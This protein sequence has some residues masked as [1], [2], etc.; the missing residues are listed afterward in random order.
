MRL[1]KNILGNYTKPRIFLCDTNKKKICQLYTT[2]TRGSFKFNSCSELSFET[3]RI[4]NDVLT[5][6][7]KVNP[8]YDR[9]ESPRLILLE[10]F[11]YFEIQCPELNSDGIKESKSVTAYSLEYTLSTKFLKNFYVNTGKVDSL[12]VLN[13][14]NPD[15]I[16][17]IV[18]CDKSNPKLSLLHL[19]LEE[20]YGW[21]VGYVSPSLQT[22]SRQF[23]V[24]RESVYD[25]LM[26]EICE[27]FNCYIV[28]DTFNNEINIYAES[29]TSK[30][31][32]DGSTNIF[33]ISPPFSQINTVSVDGYKT[34]RWSYNAS[35]GVL[36]LEDIPVYGARIEIIDGSLK[37]W[38]TDVFVSFDNLAKDVNVSYDADAI[39]TKL[40]VTYGDDLDIREA[41]LGLPYLTDLS[42]YYNVDWMGQD[43]YD[44]YTAYLQ[45]S[46]QY[47]T[48]YTN[49]SQAMLDIAGK[50]DFAENRLSLEYAKVSV[51][52]TA[53]GTYYV[54]VGEYPNHYYREVTLPADYNVNTTYYSDETTNLQDTSEGNVRKLYEALKKYFNNTN[55]WG[56]ELSALSDLFVFMH[57][58]PVSWL[59]EQLNAVSSDRAKNKNIETAIGNF[60]NEMWGQ[61]GR[62]PLKSLYYEQYKQIQ[63]ANIEAGWSQENNA[64]YGSYYPVVLYLNSLENAINKRNI[65]IE[66]YEEQYQE[67]QET[68]AA[69]GKELLMNKN[70]TEDQLIRLSAFLREDELHLDDIVET[71]LTSISE[72]FALKQDAM[73]S[74]RI[75]LQKLCQPQ[76]QFTMNMANIYAIP[77]FEPIIGQ[78]Q[79]GNVI[80][81]G[82]R[83][84][85]IKQSRLL[86]VDLNFDDFSD[87]SCEFGE[88]TSLRTQSDIH[89]DLLSQAI[90]AGKSVATNS[91]YWT[92]GSD[93]ANNIDLRLQE[94]LLN[95]IEALKATGG[96]QNAYLDKYGLHLEAINPDTGEIDDKRVWLVNNQIVFTDDGFKTS[97]SALGEFTVDGETYYG[98]L[99][100]AV[101]AGYI[102]GSKIKGGTI[103]IGLQPDG[104]YAFEVHEDGSVTM[105]GGS[106]VD[107]VPI[108]NI[109]GDQYSCSI[110]FLSGSNMFMGNDKY[111]IAQAV[112][113]K[114]NKEIDPPVTNEYYEGS[115][116]IDETTNIITTDLDG[117]FEQ[118]R[119]MYFVYKDND[120]YNIVLAKYE[121]SAWIA[122]KDN[123]YQYIYQNNSSSGAS[124]IALIERANVEQAFN[125]EFS[126]LE[127]LVSRDNLVENSKII[128]T[129][130][131]FIFNVK[132]TIV[133]DTPPMSPEEGQLWID[134][135]NGG[136]VLK[137]YAS[138]RWINVNE[139]NGGAIYTSRPLSYNKGDLWILESDYGKYKVGSILK[140]EVSAYSED[141]DESHWIDAMEETTTTLKNIKESFTWDETGIKIAK[142]EIDSDGYVTTPFYVHIDSTR[143]GFHSRTEI[144]GSV[145]DVEVVHVGNN[146]ATIQ[147]ATFE[148]NDGTIVNND[149]TVNG[150][151]TFNNAINMRN[152]NR[153]GGFIFQ[154]EDDGSFSLALA[155]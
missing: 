154:V 73:E 62:I 78:F 51:D 152:L 36:T 90:S 37:E 45:K 59:Y 105:N 32:G 87:L 147:N 25:F 53:V 124:R 84:D 145:D 41:N 151:S 91:S 61:I 46:N 153:M 108:E 21:K 81:V 24:D 126:V 30:F 28:F 68:N 142:R 49:N 60:L 70:F 12:E 27:K 19:V 54:K 20:V 38:E 18:L 16:I 110:A 135:S 72:S 3:A 86:Q 17:P 122:V 115:V 4:Y 11:G 66:G 155:D 92:K 77:E 137:I 103:Q 33:T 44:A 132:N 130:S 138:D 29:L 80:K 47:Q 100:Q 121:N 63:I 71:D 64:N 76:L 7:T 67:I 129:A 52:E 15:K 128:A 139:Q 75:E 26:N 99:A 79:L 107:G 104:T 140:A 6:H 144:N 141:F 89:A 134:T 23:E 106:T 1:P 8:F 82:I 146:S 123:I 98:L 2:E 57:M 50:I 65:E 113:Y 136:F 150:G 120:K 109:T 133:S 96:N 9:I 95:S 48:E 35:T 5:G 22:L 119:Y 88:L 114:G 94:G 55:D 112:L 58:Y 102:E 116:V 42:Y 56:S 74:G 118:G 97:K 101:I 39:K 111:I 69:I 93:R 117:E 85:Y 127:E 125:L 149:M 13:A 34:T 40:V 131:S 143:M 83:S 10:G 14:E 148:G 43:L 31:I